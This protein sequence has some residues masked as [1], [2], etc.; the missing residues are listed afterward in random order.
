MMRDSIIE[1]ESFLGPYSHEHK[2]KVGNVQ[3]MTWV[4]DQHGPY[5]MNRARRESTKYDKS[6]G[7]SIEVELTKDELIANLKR[8]GVNAK[9]KKDHLVNLCKNNN[10]P[11]TKTVTKVEEGWSGKA[12]GAL[13]ILYER[14]WIDPKKSH[15]YYT[16]AGKTDIY[17]N[18]DET[19]SIDSLIAKQPDFL[20]Q[21]TLL[22]C[23]AKELGVESDRSPVCH[24]EI[25]GEG[26]EFNWG[27]AKVHYRSE[28]IA[29]K[30][31]KENFYSLVDECLGPTVLSI[32]QCRNNARR[33]R[34]YMLAYKA[35]EDSY[36]T[37]NQNKKEEK[38]IKDSARY[39][40]TLIEKCISLFRK[41]RSHRNNLDF[42]NK[43]L[44]D[45]RVKS[46]IQKMCKPEPK[47]EVN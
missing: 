42:D 40:H 29:R 46:I 38:K 1:D 6:D 16:K 20:E 12:K 47:V 37:S 18:I 34:M 25:A 14:G 24:P 8:I 36:T 22:Q 2:L 4:E 39:N 31:S 26:I 27:C 33:A 41:R 15:M 3:H 21:E 32:T 17:G 9:G 28:P 35:L 45:E 19:T 30:R 44:K 7:S 11:L 43:Y 23:Y 5:Y 10:L 13:Q